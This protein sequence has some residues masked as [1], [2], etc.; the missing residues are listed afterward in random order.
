MPSRVGGLLDYR[1]TCRRVLCGSQLGETYLVLL[2]EECV[3]TLMLQRPGTS[4]NLVRTPLLLLSGTSCRIVALDTCCSE[5]AVQEIGE[6]LQLG[7][8]FCNDVSQLFT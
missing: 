7:E 4:G 6:R 8:L 1:R 5:I 2:S 3:V